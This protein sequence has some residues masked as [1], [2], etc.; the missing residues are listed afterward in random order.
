MKQ[1]VVR[2]RTKP[3]STEENRRLIEAVFRELHA[4]APEGIRYASLALEDGTFLHIAF[5]DENAPSMASFETFKKFQD[6]IEERCLEQPQFSSSTV[7]GNYGQ[8]AE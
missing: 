3:E 1:T 8:F 6:K 4:K 2:Y 7:V 5:A